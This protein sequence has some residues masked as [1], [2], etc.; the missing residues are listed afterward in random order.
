MNI[1]RYFL[2]I[3]SLLIACCA[4]SQLHCK[5]QL[6]LTDNPRWDISTWT[7]GYGGDCPEGVPVEF[8]LLSI[9]AAFGAA[10]GILYMA[11]T[12]KL[13]G[14]RRRSEAG[15]CDAGSGTISG[16][17]GCHLHNFVFGGEDGSYWQQAADL[18]W[19]GEAKDKTQ[20]VM[21]FTQTRGMDRNILGNSNYLQR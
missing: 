2:I 16:Y 15:T 11:L 14:R 10:F 6:S 1:K 19:H 21:E 8:G 9:L 18:L 3:I 4:C 12:I 7:S 17:Y 5:Y 13:G 20:S